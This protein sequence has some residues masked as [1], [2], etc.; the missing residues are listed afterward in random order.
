MNGQLNGWI[1]PP[2]SPSSIITPVKQKRRDKDSDAGSYTKVGKRPKQSGDGATAT[3]MTKRP[4]TNTTNLQRQITE[5]QRD[6]RGLVERVQRTEANQR[7]TD[8]ALVE[9]ADQAKQA[10][11]ESQENR[12]RLIQHQRDH[13]RQQRLDEETGRL[14]HL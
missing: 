1:H 8:R 2:S 7:T 3:N 6:T 9:V 14:Q 4:A 5:L 10:L 11:V 12:S 13:L